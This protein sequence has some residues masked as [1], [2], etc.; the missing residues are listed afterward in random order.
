MGGHVAEFWIG[1]GL[2]GEFGQGERTVVAA[3]ARAGS[4]PAGPG[5]DGEMCDLSRLAGVGRGTAAPAG[6]GAGSGTW[7]KVG[8]S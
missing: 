1:A 8:R 4:G 3:M 6:T 5:W 7:K 2:V